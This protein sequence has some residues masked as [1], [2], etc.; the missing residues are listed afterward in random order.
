MHYPHSFCVCISCDVSIIHKN[1]AF[2]D[3]AFI[4]RLLDLR[5]DVDKT[6][7]GGE[8]E[9]KFLPPCFHALSSCSVHGTT[10]GKRVEIHIL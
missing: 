3:C 10:D 7:P 1:E 8:I 4:H 6:A 5:G 9:M 2:S